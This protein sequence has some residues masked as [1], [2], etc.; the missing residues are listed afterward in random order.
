MRGHSG[1]VVRFAET[2][3]R[4]LVTSAPSLKR[5]KNDDPSHRE[6]RSSRCDVSS[7]DAMRGPTGLS[8]ALHVGFVGVVVLVTSWDVNRHVAANR[9]PV[10]RE[11]EES[12]HRWKQARKL[13]L[14]SASSQSSIRFMETLASWGGSEDDTGTNAGGQRERHGE[15]GGG[16]DLGRVDEESI[17]LRKNS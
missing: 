12:I 8:K 15:D 16:R 5:N 3:I 7:S 11:Q 14:E 2:A 1:V 17:P 9:I 4:G 6:S 13:E 10:S